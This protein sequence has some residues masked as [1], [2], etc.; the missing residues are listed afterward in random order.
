[1]VDLL[2]HLMILKI[3]DQTTGIVVKNFRAETE[4]GEYK[5]EVTMLVDRERKEENG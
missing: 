5:F 1:M 3:R 4:F 2:R